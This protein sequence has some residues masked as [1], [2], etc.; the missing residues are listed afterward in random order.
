MEKWLPHK[1]TLLKNR[2]WQTSDQTQ[3]VFSV[4][5]PTELGQPSAKVTAETKHIP[6]KEKHILC[7]HYLKLFST[8]I[9]NPKF[10]YIFR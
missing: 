6:I 8:I 1:V 3:Q 5:F 10:I 7:R 9:T 2:T 4:G